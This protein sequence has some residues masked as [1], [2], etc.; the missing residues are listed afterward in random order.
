MFIEL[1][2][3]LYSNHQ[4]FTNFHDNSKN[5]DRKNQKIYFSIGSAHCASSIKTGSKLKGGEG[6][7]IFNWGKAIQFLFA[8]FAHTFV[9]FSFVYVIR[10]ALYCTRCT[11]C[12]SCTANI[13]M[14]NIV[15]PAVNCDNA[16]TTLRK[17]YFHF[18]T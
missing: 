11:S 4:N 14:Y 7:H 1:W 3:F 9:Q 5:R 10:N 12:T 16:F 2:S 13:D 17:L 15:R 8:Q 18:L 6:L